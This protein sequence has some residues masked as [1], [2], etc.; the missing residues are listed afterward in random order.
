MAEINDLLSI[1][2]LSEIFIR[3]DSLKD[4]Q[5][6]TLVCTLWK[7]AS[8]LVVSDFANKFVAFDHTRSEKTS[9]GNLYQ[10]YNSYYYL[11]NKRLHG[12]WMSIEY[13]TK[14]KTNKMIAS[15]KVL[16]DFRFG[17]QINS[18]VKDYDINDTND[19]GSLAVDITTMK[20]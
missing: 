3:L 11:P 20:E 4:W 15:R 1:D 7:E 17:K 2:T 12:T 10:K 8:N 13:I 5:N 6:V 18:Q 14:C 16:I 19:K 9:N